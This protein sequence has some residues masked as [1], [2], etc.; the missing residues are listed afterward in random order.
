MA[1]TNKKIYEMN[2]E[3]FRSFLPGMEP[4]V[5][6][7][8][9]YFKN[10]KLVDIH[11][12]PDFLKLCQEFMSVDEYA[13][14]IF[15]DLFSEDFPDKVIVPENYRFTYGINV[16]KRYWEL[17]D[18]LTKQFN[19]SKNDMKHWT[20]NGSEYS[21]CFREFNE[22]L[23]NLVES[24]DY[25]KSD[26]YK[27]IVKQIKEEPYLSKEMLEVNE[28]LSHFPVHKYPFWDYIHLLSM[29]KLW[30]YTQRIYTLNP[31]LALDFLNQNKLIIPYSALKY[32]DYKVFYLNFS[33]IKIILEDELNSAL[34]FSIEGVWVRVAKTEECYYI[35]LIYHFKN[36]S[37]NY[38]TQRCFRVDKQEEFSFCRKIPFG[39]ELIFNDWKKRF[40]KLKEQDIGNNLKDFMKTQLS[41]NF[42]IDYSFQDY[43][44]Y[45]IAEKAHSVTGKDYY[46]GYH[47]YLKNI[48]LMDQC[49]FNQAT[50]TPAQCSLGKYFNDEIRRVNADLYLY[51]KNFSHQEILEE[52][53]DFV[54]YTEGITRIT[55][56]T[57]FY[58][59][60]K[61]NHVLNPN[62]KTEYV[63]G[64]SK[65]AEKKEYT[66]LGNHL[67][68][69]N[70]SQSDYDS[71]DGIITRYIGTGKGR[72]LTNLRFTHGHYHYYW[73][74]SR[75]DGTYHKEEEPHYIEPYTSNL[76]GKRVE[77]ITM[78]TAS[79]YVN[80]EKK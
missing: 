7:T 20:K 77:N 14:R 36:G 75:K 68:Y 76:D 60:C 34:Q 74:G 48:Q 11:E 37:E 67:N 27:Y 71:K 17:E 56:C 24:T 57:I 72:K 53:S 35:F 5:S 54:W 3:D 31:N 2:E 44:R 39:T 26:E 1:K 21:G 6:D 49:N 63:F 23:S 15:F 45:L 47:L 59:C 32:L 73:V 65:P 43:M 10:G 13:S 18:K 22:Q 38:F 25:Q 19:M 33:D 62:Q 58:L 8:Y 55:L 42:E 80:K 50:I 52:T 69:L 4:L 41:D 30:E 78:I 66:P 46:K 51:D 16:V 29:K 28:L 61:G 9:K 64:I 12:V 70:L 40:H 79:E